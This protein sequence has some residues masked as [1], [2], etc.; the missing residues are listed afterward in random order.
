[1]VNASNDHDMYFSVKL[2]KKISHYG[3]ELPYQYSNDSFFF[4]F[5]LIIEVQSVRK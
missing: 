1:M 2:Q 3:N 4:H 5:N